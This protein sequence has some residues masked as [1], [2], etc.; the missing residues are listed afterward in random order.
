MRIS[1]FNKEDFTKEELE[2]LFYYAKDT[3]CVNSVADLYW[4]PERGGCPHCDYGDP[5]GHPSYNTLKEHSPTCLM[6]AVAKIIESKG[7][8]FDDP[9]EKFQ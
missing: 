6:M 9:S 1:E 4:P 3:L 8:F 2:T 5:N 7:G